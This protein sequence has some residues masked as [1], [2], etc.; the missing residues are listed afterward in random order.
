MELTGKQRRYLR[1]LGHHLSPVVRVGQAGL[2]EALEAKT[3]A[4][5][6]NHELIKVK[7]GDGADDSPK[8]AAEHLAQACD[9][10]LVQVLGG[11][12]LLYRPREKDPEIR[13]PK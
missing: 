11:T 5:L 2:T 9:A 3:A 8:S 4:E 13:L 7:V 6:E 1:G 12:A 10:A